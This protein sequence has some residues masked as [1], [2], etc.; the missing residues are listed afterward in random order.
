MVASDGSTAYGRSPMTVIALGSTTLAFFSVAIFYTVPSGLNP[1]LAD[2][3]IL[4]YLGSFQ[5]VAYDLP[6][7]CVIAITGGA[8]FSRNT[9]VV[10]GVYFA[11]IAMA[12][13]GV[14]LLFYGA[15]NTV[16]IPS[17]GGTQF[18]VPY[19]LRGGFSFAVGIFMV[20]MNM[21]M[22]YAISKDDRKR[23]RHAAGN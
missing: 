21:I 11:G 2:H 23:T 18:A 17:A 13:A 16:I 8:A 6:V 5:F 4:G 10:R 20:I 15:E 1:A 22:Q 14:I 3:P 7:F 9:R 12:S 19:M